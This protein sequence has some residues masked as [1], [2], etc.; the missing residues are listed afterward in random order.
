MLHYCIELRAQS[1][2]RLGN[3]N[4]DVWST[5]L[6]IR[7]T[8]LLCVSCPNPIALSESVLPATTAGPPPCILSARTVATSTTA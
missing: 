1:K 8:L 2:T 6:E 3:N 5:K 7:I 4:G